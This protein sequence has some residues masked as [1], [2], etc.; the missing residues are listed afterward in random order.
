VQLKTAHGQGVASEHYEPGQ[1]VFEQGDVGD[2]LYII[3]KGRCAVVRDEGGAERELADLGPG[4][5]FGEMALLSQGP[6]TATIRCTEPMDVL[7]VPK[8]EIGVLMGHL[9]PLRDS[10]EQLALQRAGDVAGPR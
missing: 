6:R 9:P 3:L 1:C 4:E 8:T 5:F 10:L 7:S 2:R